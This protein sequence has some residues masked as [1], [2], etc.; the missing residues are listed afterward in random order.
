[1]RLRLA[2]VL[3]ATVLTSGAA[4]AEPPRR[5]D[6]VF[7]ADPRF[8]MEGGV[9]TFGSLGRLVYRYE[10]ALP[11]IVLVDEHK[12]TGKLAGVLGRSLQIQQRESL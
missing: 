4:S 1:M 11:T 3:L 8:G 7:T 5:P 10:E 9:R 2:S 12:V 6:Y